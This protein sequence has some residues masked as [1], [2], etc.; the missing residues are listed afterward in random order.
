MNN[1]VLILV[2]VVVLLL[3]MVSPTETFNKKTFRATFINNSG[4]PFAIYPK[5]DSPTSCNYTGNLKEGKT[6]VHIPM[7]CKG[8]PIWGDLIFSIG[9]D[10]MF[11]SDI[12]FEPN[13]K[14]MITKDFELKKL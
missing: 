1:V 4:G 9:Q 5:D 8:R 12:T 6:T 11:Q 2:V 14:Y 7:E 3:I 10:P 13:G